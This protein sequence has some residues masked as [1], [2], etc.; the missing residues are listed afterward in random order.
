MSRA[1]GEETKDLPVTYTYCADEYDLFG[2]FMS[3]WANDYPDI[4]WLELRTF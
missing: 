4:I 3:W 1:F 2:K